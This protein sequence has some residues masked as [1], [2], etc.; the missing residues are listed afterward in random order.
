[1]GRSV[2]TYTPISDSEIVLDDPITESLITRYRNNP[3]AIAEGSTGAPKFQT[4]AYQDESVDRAALVVGILTSQ[5]LTDVTGAVYTFPHGRGARPWR[6]D[7][8]LECLSADHGYS[9]GDFIMAPLKCIKYDA[10]STQGMAAWA[11]ATNVYLQMAANGGVVMHKT[12]YDAQILTASRWA[13][14]VY[15]WSA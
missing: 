1:M 11:D 8:W 13:A 9:D 7:I 12:S 2:T 6:V 4:A 15:P 3:L 14:H 10:T 5:T